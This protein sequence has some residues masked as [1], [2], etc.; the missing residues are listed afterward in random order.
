[1]NP[2]PN[3]SYAQVTN[4]P[5]SQTNTQNSE[6]LAQQMALFLNNLQATINALISLLTTL[7]EKRMLSNNGK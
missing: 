6:H 1:M 5:P 4:N 7:V 2:Q 3:K